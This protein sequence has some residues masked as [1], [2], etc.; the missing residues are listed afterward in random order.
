MVDRLLELEAKLAACE[1][2]LLALIPQ[3]P[4]PGRLLATLAA[5]QRDPSVSR[6]AAVCEHLAKLQSAIRAGSDTPSAGT[7]RSPH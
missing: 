7:P 1:I 3:L 4:D 5:I 6:R 2:V